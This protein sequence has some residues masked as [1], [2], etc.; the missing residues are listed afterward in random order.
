MSNDEGTRCI[1]PHPKQTECPF[2]SLGMAVACHSR[3]WSLR[4]RDAWIWGIVCG[5][6]D[7][8]LGDI[9]DRLLWSDESVA[10]LKRLR[11]EFVRAHA[12]LHPLEAAP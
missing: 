8:S 6:D 10:R 12:L 9:Q 3:D 2:A 1:Q 11:S 5:W 4:G 7:E